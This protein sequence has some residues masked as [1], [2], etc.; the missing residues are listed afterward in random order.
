MGGLPLSMHKALLETPPVCDGAESTG[1]SLDSALNRLPDELLLAIFEWGQTSHR[2]LVEDLSVHLR[3]LAY[4]WEEVLSHV[5]SRW[6]TVVLCA[7][8][9]WNFIRIMPDQSIERTIAYVDRSGNCPLHIEVNTSRCD[10]CSVAPGGILQ[11]IDAIYASIGRWH[12]LS[13]YANQR[14]M[15]R[16][17]ATKISA[18]ELPVL[19][20]VDMS[21]ECCWDGPSQLSQMFTGAP[22]LAVLDLEC[23]SNFNWNFGAL[24]L[25]SLTLRASVFTDYPA[26]MDWDTL[27]GLLSTVPQLEYLRLSGPVIDFESVWGSPQLRTVEVPSLETMIVD[28]YEGWNGYH[29]YL[30]RGISAPQLRHLHILLENYQNSEAPI[31]D[32]LSQFSNPGGGPKFP[33]LR[34][35]VLGGVTDSHLPAELFVYRFPQVS[36]LTLA[37]NDVRNFA[38]ALLAATRLAE[39]IPLDRRG[40]SVPGV[41]AWSQLR[42]VTLTDLRPWIW[43]DAAEKWR[44]WLAAQQKTAGTGEEGKEEKFVI[45]VV[46]YQSHGID[47]FLED[48]RALE[49]VATVIFTMPHPAVRHRRYGKFD[50]PAEVAALLA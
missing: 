6:R 7:P 24:G 12:R 8:L 16:A 21:S 35:L 33:L 37:G 5:C 45:E 3:P 39:S 15:T 1:A 26:L 47:A 14:K 38:D 31:V 50:T 28:T 2:Y 41:G 34:T 46:P 42:R 32:M 29:W 13:L 18:M 44:K 9:M 17:L 27:R 10:D 22:R 36:S 48:T 20:H 40:R 4:R 23:I 49:E 19:T 30:F 11:H 25:S 43:K